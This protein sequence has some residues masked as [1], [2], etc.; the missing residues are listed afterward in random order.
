MAVVKIPAA[1]VYCFDNPRELEGPTPLFTRVPIPKEAYPSSL[2]TA[3]DNIP[4]IRPIDDTTPLGPSEFS[5]RWV[6][7]SAKVSIT[8]FWACSTAIFTIACPLEDPT[9]PMPAAPI[10]PE[11]PI[12]IALGYDTGLYGVPKANLKRVF[13]GYVDTVTYKLTPKRVMAIV[14]LRDPIRFLVDNK[15]TK[16]Y[17]ANETQNLDQN[18]VIQGDRTEI[19]KKLIEDGSGRYSDGAPA[20]P[21]SRIFALQSERA[22]ILPVDQGTPTDTASG[23]GPKVPQ[24]YNVMNRFPI[25]IIKHLSSVE[26]HPRELYADEFGRV[27]WDIR[28]TNL[29]PDPADESKIIKPRD[30]YFRN[31]VVIDTKE[32]A[33]I[34]PI[35]TAS[36]EWSTI[37]TFTEFV[38]VNADSN[39]HGVSGGSLALRGTL[40]AQKALGFDMA[41][42]TRFVFDDTLQNQEVSQIATGA[43]LNAM[44]MLH[45]KDVRAGS[46]ETEGEPTIKPSDAIRVWNTAIYK[47]PNN[48]FRVEAV[49]HSFTGAGPKK[50]FRTNIMFSATEESLRKYY[51]L[52]SFSIGQNHIVP[53]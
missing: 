38:V 1:I 28:R 10:H 45:G 22:S 34:Y 50:G 5:D 14:A 25:E 42:R 52:D 37:G 47:P 9:Q 48:I 49:V 15:L 6:L 44:L 51:N 39:S 20:I 3:L 21:R 8:R 7:L 41:I 40:D 27:F 36:M 16:I 18:I 32:T 2:L 23:S 12:T 53:G 29:G 11:M 30:Y 19:I 46:I 17:D 35:I 43:F 33:G 24:V 13:T 31:P 26:G 4:V